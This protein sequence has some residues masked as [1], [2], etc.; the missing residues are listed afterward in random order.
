MFSLILDLETLVIE[1]KGIAE[2][3]GTLAF[4]GDTGTSLDNFKNA[5]HLLHGLLDDNSRKLEN[6]WK[7]MSAEGKQLR[8]AG[9]SKKDGNAA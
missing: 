9:K 3:M 6:L 4:A 1:A 2:L 5:A 7:K 8:T